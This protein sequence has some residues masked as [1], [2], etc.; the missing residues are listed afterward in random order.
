LPATVRNLTFNNSANITLTASTNPSNTLTFTAGNVITN[1]NVLS[2]GTSTTILGTLVRTSGHVVGNFRRWVAAATTSNI[3]FPVGT[4][5]TY[6]GISCS[7]TTVPTAGTITA[8]FV[9]ETVGLNGLPLTESS[10]T[11]ST[12]S[13][14]YWSLTAGNSFAGG[15]YNV[16][17]FANGITGVNDY[18]QLRLIRRVNSGSPWT[19]NGTHAVAT[20]SNT[21][22]VVNRTGMNVLGHYGIGSSNVN[23][24]PIE[25]LYFKAKAAGNKVELTWATSAEKDNDF[26]TVE[27]STDGRNFDVLLTKPGAGDSRV[28]LTYNAYDERPTGNL[29]YY[30]L[31]Q[32]DFDGK[33]TYSEIASVRMEKSTANARLKT[34]SVGP[35]PFTDSFRMQFMLE[36]AAEAELTI[37]SIN[38]QLVHRE[39]IEGAS[40]MNNYEF[41]DQQGLKPGIYIVAIATA[42]ERI[43]QKLVKK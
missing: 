18:T 13:D 20:G 40:G 39:K 4:P 17:V 19:F 14:F 30:R 8:S 10:Q 41:Y 43:T 24:L 9:P 28:T 32:T 3:L 7:F 31:K 42:E 23:A 29:I 5:G 38:G 16:N 12:V 1:S 33:F 15:V 37:T 26:F 6:N 25:L 21:S 36:E 35:N 22:P 27:R 34:E 11:V 2:L